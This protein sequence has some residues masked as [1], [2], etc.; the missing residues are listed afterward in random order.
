MRKSNRSIIIEQP[1]NR[2]EVL[3]IL[4]AK[5]TPKLLLEELT[6]RLYHEEWTV[7]TCGNLLLIHFKLKPTYVL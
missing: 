7:E 4:K 1:T 5:R 2:H 3:E 6:D